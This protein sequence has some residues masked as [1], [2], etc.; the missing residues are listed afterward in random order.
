LGLSF[1][2]GIVHENNFMNILFIHFPKTFSEFPF[3]GIYQLRY[4]IEL[5]PEGMLIT[6]QPG[7]SILLLLREVF[8]P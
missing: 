6:E 5:F 2:S 7:A 8:L 1:G 3:D 4:A